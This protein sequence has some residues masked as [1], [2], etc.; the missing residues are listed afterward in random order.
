M[1]FNHL[2]VPT[3]WQ[4]YWTRFPEGHTILE[5]LIQWVSQ[6]DD[7]VDNQN[8]LSDTVTAYGERLD[9]FIDQFEGNLAEEVKDTLGEW[10][11]SG[12]IDV[13]ISEALQWQLDDYIATNDQDKASINSQL[14][15]LGV[16]VVNFGGGVE[17][18]DN[19]DAIMSAIQYATDNDLSKV[20]LPPGEVKTSPLNLKGHRHITLEGTASLYYPDQLT[21]HN[22]T[23][24]KL[25]SEGEVGVQLNAVT[26][27]DGSTAWRTVSNKLHNIKIDCN[28]MV[29]YGVN[30]A[31]DV[32][33][34]HVYVVNAKLDGIVLEATTYPV[35]FNNIFSCYNGRH[36][37]YARS[38]FT[39]VY[40]SM[41]SEFSRN[42]GY[43]I[44]IEGGTNVKFTNTVIQKNDQ[45]GLK[46][47][48]PNDSLFTNPAYLQRIHFD[49]LYTEANGRLTAD[50]E[51]YEGN[52]AVLISSDNPAKR[53]SNIKIENSSLFQSSTGGTLKIDSADM[54]YIDADT[55]A[56]AKIE[57]NNDN[58][59][60]L[61]YGRKISEVISNVN[62]GGIR[63]YF[64]RY[65]N[66]IG[67]NGGVFPTQGRTTVLYYYV[68]T[69]GQ[70]ATYF[71]T[72]AIALPPNIT[73]SSPAP[74]NGY[75]VLKNGS[76][77]YIS[78][79]KTGEGANLSGNIRI[80]PKQKN[81][82]TLKHKETGAELVINWD[83][84]ARG[85]EYAQVFSPGQYPITR[86][87]MLGF[88]FQ[89]RGHNIGSYTDGWLISV[90]VEY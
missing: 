13:V 30:G 84:V 47:N 69:I 19:H 81:G 10:Q 66:G 90:L 11:A 41:N 77:L 76:I 18:E 43:G 60:G 8:K 51:N 63:S 80:T 12:F 73:P 42:G 33:L 48:Y 44:L 16:Y 59:K 83:L 26:Q 24:L 55:S 49:G 74:F 35:K 68:D 2:N 32:E 62:K 20:I 17:V 65:T 39:T 46:I 72:P 14:A 21:A 38:P 45:G 56:Q 58:V 70:W 89:T 64:E 3:H 34:D 88:E 52:W 23:T 78:A 5:A 1:K 4:N 71:A 40:Y 61:E 7:M 6:V 27:L 22:G 57:V 85:K 28:S 9:E 25:V 54:V 82:G 50:N 87:D 86:G 36:G 15:Q 37:L 67:V 53:P 29:Y 31:F 75:P 79:M